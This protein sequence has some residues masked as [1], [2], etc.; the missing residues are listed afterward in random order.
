MPEKI[1]YIL[2]A[3]SGALA[4]VRA[5]DALHSNCTLL[6]IIYHQRPKDKNNSSLKILILK[7]FR[8]F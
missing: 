2:R 4:M 1:L 5:Y 8:R 3:G 7:R 6:S